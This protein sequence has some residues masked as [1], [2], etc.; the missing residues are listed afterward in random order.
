MAD[1]LAAETLPPRSPPQPMTTATVPPL[2]AGPDSVP[3]TLPFVGD[4]AT[5]QR[6]AACVDTASVP[7][8]QIL[9]EL[10]RGGMG[11]VYQARQIG[12]NRIVALK[13]ILSGGHASTEELDRFRR[14]AEAVARLQH[15]N[16][17]QIH[18]IGQVGGLPYFSLEFCAGGSLAARMKGTPLPPKVAADVVEQLARAMAYA[19][20]Q[21]IVHRD[22]KPANILLAS[23]TESTSRAST[24]HN[25]P[26]GEKGPPLA[27][28]VPKVTDFGLAKRLE[29]CDGPTQSGAVMGT[30]SYMAPE[31]AVGDAK[32]AGPSVDVYAL[33]AILY[34][35]LTG[36]PP[37][38]AATSLDTI[39]QVIEHEPVTPSPAERPHTAGPG[40][41]RAEMPR[42]RSVPALRFGG[43]VGGGP[44]TVAAGRADNG[45]ADSVVEPSGSVGPTAADDGD[46]DRRHRGRGGQ[47]A[48][49]GAV[50]QRPPG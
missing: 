24:S 47:P 8:Y 44:G 32:R 2:S 27:C 29:A 37:F 43:G 18:E 41:G 31:Q 10:G 48:R 13:M 19:H 38:K 14:E 40:N 36:R 49:W 9:C 22:L 7:G 3:S 39:L 28:L 16:I 50:V 6:L 23:V 17:V 45:P 11:V 42:E 15:P 46:P 30:P 21:G 26:Q 5:P 34:E 33:G 4:C 25:N 12:L 35:C 20:D 1:S